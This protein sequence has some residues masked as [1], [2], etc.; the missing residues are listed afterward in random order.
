MITATNFPGLRHF[1]LRRCLSLLSFFACAIVAEGQT[2]LKYIPSTADVV[3]TLNLPSIDKKVNL[4]QLQ[5][6]DFYQA[7]LKDMQKSPELE[8]DT[9]MQEF[10]DKLLTD[11]ASLG[12]SVGEPYYFVVEKVG[13]DNY[14]T[15]IQKLDNRSIYEAAVQRM[16]GAS[17]LENLTQNGSMSVWQKGTETFAWNDEVVLN[18]KFYKGYNPNEFNYGYDETAVDYEEDDDIS[19]F[20]YGMEPLPD[21]DDNGLQ[22]FLDENGDTIHLGGPDFDI[23]WAALDTM[24]FN[25]QDSTMAWVPDPD[26]SAY[27]WAMKVMNRDFLQP[28]S[29]NERFGLAKGRTNDVHFWMDY[30]YFVENMNSMQQL[31]LGGMAATTGYAKAMSMMG[32]MMDVFYGDTYFSMGLNFEDGRMAIRNQLFFNEDMKRFYS[33]AMD[34][35]FNKKMLR[36]VKGGDEMFGYF[37][38]NYNIKNTI[39]ESKSLIYKLLA[40]TP[41]YGDMGADMM[42]IM[43]IF[44]DEESIGN[45]LKGDMLVSVSGLQ[46]VEVTTKTYEYDADFN[47]TEKDTVVMQTLPV[48]TMQASY[49]NGKDIQKFIDLGIHSKVLVKEGAFY[50]VELPDMGGMKMYLAMHD[51]L[52]IFTNNQYLMQQNLGTGFAKKLRLPKN[53]K[54]RFCK[55]AAVVYWN[56]PNTIK[57][58]AGSQAESNVGIT[59][60]M[61]N[62]GKQFYSLDL[63]TDK[64][65]GDSVESEMYLNMTQK[66]TNA[67]QQFFNF[68]ND[69][70]LETIGGAKI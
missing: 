43:G 65:V 19:E 56:I 29:R 62:L 11:P 67:L 24:T 68:V 3:V 63:T 52:L 48:F 66:D 14:I 33:K 12:F 41:Q 34:G 57:A 25:F 40:A 28:I 64:K 42:K 8:G 36:Y 23:D 37:Y 9:A 2:A 30:G 55:N 18:V 15:I 47:Y 51:G 16:K 54:K 49:G 39:E 50:R 10:T 69:I 13:Y 20:D 61:N 4:A 1:S 58:A 45:L 60:W 32:G 26:T 21:L 27:N 38:M 46:T 31:G 59:G 35:K 6:Y 22:Q 70:Y 7:M 17:Y 53:H 5:Q 44:I